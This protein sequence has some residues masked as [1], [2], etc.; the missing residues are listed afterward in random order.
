MAALAVK[1]DG[2]H[3]P[4]A[5]DIDA[6]RVAARQFTKLDHGGAIRFKPEANEASEDDAVE[7]ITIPANIFRIMIQMLVEMGNGNAVAVV[8]ISAELTTQQA[9]DLLNVSRPHLVKLLH[10][11]VLQHRMVGT[12]RKLKAKDVLTY[13]SKTE[14]DRRVALTEMAELEN[15]LD[16]SG[17]KLDEAKA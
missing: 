6:A 13:R 3:E 15:G 8:P 12:H 10:D 9:A 2:L 11:G 4:S 17:D 16:L 14:L 5:D 1:L 7:P